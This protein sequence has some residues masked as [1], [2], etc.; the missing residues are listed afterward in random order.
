MTGTRI[1]IKNMCCPRGINA[2]GAIL[3]SM[4]LT[5]KEIRLGDAVVEETLS[6][7]ETESLASKLREQ[8]FELLDDPNACIVEAIRV[9][10]LE[11]VRMTEKKPKL[12]VYVSQK[13]C[14]DYSSLSKLFSQVKGVTIEHYAIRHR[15]EYAKELLCYSIS[16]ISEIAYRL[17]YSS[18]AHFAV[19]FKQFTGM[20]PKEFRSLD[21]R[22]RM[23][24]DEL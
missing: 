22:P 6:Q 5:A 3:T 1:H 23:S 16:S 10:V 17:G 7:E 9:A 8:G 13:I 15:I 19:Q 24:L 14:K 21:Y 2:I 18:P 20:S 12:S 4:N 11:W